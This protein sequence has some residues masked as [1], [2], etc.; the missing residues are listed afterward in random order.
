MP[1]L[2][3]RGL[4]RV[5][6]FLLVGSRRFYLTSSTHIR[7]LRDQAG[8]GTMTLHTPRRAPQHDQLLSLQFDDDKTLGAWATALDDTKGW[9]ANACV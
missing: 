3:L 6:T 7:L 2:R 4:P 8:T 9:L 1:R 5:P